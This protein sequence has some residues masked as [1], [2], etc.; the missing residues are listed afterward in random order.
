MFTVT[1]NGLVFNSIV[2]F[3]TLNHH[4]V[5]IKSLLLWHYTATT[6]GNLTAVS[7]RALTSTAHQP[8]SLIGSPSWSSSSFPEESP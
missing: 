3:F 8:W 4:G 6:L 5:P 7:L 2:K 1:S